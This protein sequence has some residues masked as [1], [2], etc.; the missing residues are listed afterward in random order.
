MISGYCGEYVKEVKPGFVYLDVSEVDFENAPQIREELLQYVRRQGDVDVDLSKVWRI[1]TVG[2]AVLIEA[3]K[4]N[5]GHM[6]VSG[7]KPLVKSSLEIAGVVDVL[8][9]LDQSA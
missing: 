3:E 5:G 8:H 2:T 4:V 6:S 7:L 1:G 9:A